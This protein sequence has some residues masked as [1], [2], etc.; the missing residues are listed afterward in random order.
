MSH[1]IHRAK[2]LLSNEVWRCSFLNTLL[3]KDIMNISSVAMQFDTL[4][5]NSLGKDIMNISIDMQTEHQ[6]QLT[7]DSHQFQLH[8]FKQIKSTFQVC[9]TLCLHLQSA[10]LAWPH[11]HPQHQHQ[12]QHQHVDVCEAMAS[13]C[14]AGLLASCNALVYMQC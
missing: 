11:T 2:T 12:H 4:L 14:A 3:G 8:R 7:L 1:H 6:Q 10:Q 9:Q 5:F 13:V